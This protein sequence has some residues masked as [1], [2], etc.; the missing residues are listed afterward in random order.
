M[1]IKKTTETIFKKFVT[2][3]S[4]HTGS[5]C[6]ELNMVVLGWSVK[7]VIWPNFVDLQIDLHFIDIH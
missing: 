2:T 1:D 5:I 6:Q 7:C 4:L 3:K